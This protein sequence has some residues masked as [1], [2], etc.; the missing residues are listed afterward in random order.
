MAGSEA[1]QGL[2]HHNEAVERLVREAELA[3]AEFRE[4]SQE[5]EQGRRVPLANIERL[6]GS[7]LLTVIQSRRCGGLELSMRA[8]LDVIAAISEGC[9]STGWVLGVMHAH[10]W[11]MAHFP[12]AAQDEVYGNGAN[13]MI[14]AVIGPRGKAVRNSDGSCHL[15]GFWPFGSGCEHSDWL[16]L[17]AEV[18]EDENGTPVDAADFL[19]PTKDVELKDDWYVAGLAGT[20]SCS[21]KVDGLTV[22]AHRQLSIPALIG[23]QTPGMEE[24]YDGW[25]HRAEAVPVLAL[26]LCGGALGLARAALAEFRRTVDAK[27]VAYTPHIQSEWSATHI[28]LGEAASLIDAAHMMLYRVA[29]DIDAYARDGKAMSIE[30]R[31]RIRMDCSQG[32]KFALEGVEKLFLMAGGSSLALRSPLQ[33]AARNLHAINMHGLLLPEASAELYGRV[34]LGLDPNTEII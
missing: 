19:V 17:G 20:G 26:C 16:I 34:L 33:L 4:R 27:P 30:M 29:D 3:A 21:I 15:S 2:E 12:H 28:K 31:G 18:F 10:S 23:G 8:H 22:P 25:L 7:D 1:V 11:M 5:A 24:G 9:S 32:V 6:R 13:A 14:S